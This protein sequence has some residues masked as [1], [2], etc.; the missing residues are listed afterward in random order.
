MTELIFHI[1]VQVLSAVV[2]A[3]GGMVVRR[4]LTPA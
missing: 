1:A 4:V 3:V 2:V